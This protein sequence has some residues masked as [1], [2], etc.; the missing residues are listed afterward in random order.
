MDGGAW[1]ATVAQSQT[2]LKRL[3]MHTGTVLKDPWFTGLISLLQCN[4]GTMSDRIFELT[5]I[6]SQI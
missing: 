1:L 6:L 2:L 3:S 4:T 5:I